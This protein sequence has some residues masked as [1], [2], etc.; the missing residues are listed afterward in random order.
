MFDLV[1]TIQFF[2]QAFRK[3]LGFPKTLHWLQIRPDNTTTQNDPSHYIKIGRI[4]L[5]AIYKPNLS[6]T[7]EQHVIPQRNT[8]K[9]KERPRYHLPCST[10]TRWHS[11]RLR[12]DLAIKTNGDQIYEQTC[13]I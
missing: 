4:I 1:T 12:V 10:R 3:T 7:P 8:T 13:N 9:Y 5:C 11:S 6:F 2:F